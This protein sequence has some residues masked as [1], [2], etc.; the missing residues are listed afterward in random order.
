MNN[1]DYDNQ[2]DPGDTPMQEPDRDAA[3]RASL[4]S[5]DMFYQTHDRTVEARD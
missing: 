4:A 3:I 5:Q 1:Y 2:P